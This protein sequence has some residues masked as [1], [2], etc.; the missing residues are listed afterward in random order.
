MLCVQTNRCDFSKEVRN[1]TLGAYVEKLNS[2]SIMGHSVVTN[3]ARAIY[4]KREAIDH[5]RAVDM[6][7]LNAW[8]NYANSSNRLVIANLALVRANEDMSSV[9]SRLIGNYLSL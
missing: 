5:L 6:L 7:L 1:R 9:E 3:A 4:G 2:L 8:P